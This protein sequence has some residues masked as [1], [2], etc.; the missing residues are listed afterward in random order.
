MTNERS[1]KITC[2]RL[3]AAPTSVVGS[4][5]VPSLQRETVQTF[6]PSCSAA[7]S[8]AAPSS[9]LSTLQTSSPRLPRRALFRAHARADLVASRLEHRCQ[10]VRPVVNRLV[11]Y[12][13]ACACACACAK[14]VRSGILRG[15][16]L[17][18]AYAG[19]ALGT[20]LGIGANYKMHHTAR[21]AC[22]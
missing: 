14:H 21:G 2:R 5:R 9:V 6:S 19:H 13:C 8:G 11:A 20:I 1:A 18:C 17:W 10:I 22:I 15:H 16:A 12:T 7:G 3:P 4:T